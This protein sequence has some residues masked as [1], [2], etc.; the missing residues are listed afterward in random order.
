MNR[1]CVYCQRVHDGECDIEDLKQ[2][3][4]NLID[5]LANALD[6]ADSM[7]A[8]WAYVAQTLPPDPKGF[9]YV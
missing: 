6:R 7:Q 4:L 5:R 9:P 1:E 3:I 8:R 2:V